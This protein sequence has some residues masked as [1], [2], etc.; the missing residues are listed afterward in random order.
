MVAEALSLIIGYLIR[1]SPGIVFAAM[2]LFFVKPGKISRNGYYI[3]LIILFRDALTPLGLWSFGSQGFFWI[4]L[5]DNQFFL[6]LFG[7]FSLG[8][9]LSII[10]FDKENR[11]Y[12]VFFRRNTGLGVLDGFPGAVAVV[13]SLGIIPAAL[14]HGGAIFFLASGLL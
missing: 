12:I 9:M 2:V 13:L 5:Y 6:I 8:L 10:Y 4:R 11:E 7:V 1:T 3:F 14:T